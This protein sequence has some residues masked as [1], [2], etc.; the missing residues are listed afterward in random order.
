MQ[1]FNDI[2]RNFQIRNHSTM[3]SYYEKIIEFPHFL[4]EGTLGEGNIE[5]VIYHAR[6]KVLVVFSRNNIF[7]FVGYSEHILAV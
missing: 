6:T 3:I 2:V 4:T 1:D 7:R 5:C